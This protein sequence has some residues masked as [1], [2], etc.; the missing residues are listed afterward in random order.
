MLSTYGDVV[1][2]GVEERVE[3]GGRVVRVGRS[4][5]VERLGRFEP[6]VRVGRVTRVVRVGRDGKVN[7][8]VGRDGL[9][10]GPVG[11]VLGEVE[12]DGFGLSVLL[13]S[14]S[15]FSSF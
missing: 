8:P 13:S 12:R 2:A 3:R 5:P 9:V 4:D 10:N 7:G 14:L 11:R 15:G 6:V 1:V